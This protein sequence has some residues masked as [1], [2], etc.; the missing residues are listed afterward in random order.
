[1]QEYIDYNTAVRHHGNV[2]EHEIE[3]P[4]SLAKVDDLQDS[5][6]NLVMFRDDM[7]QLKEKHT[8]NKDVYETMFLAENEKIKKIEVISFIELAAICVMGAYQ[9]FRLKGLIA[10]RQA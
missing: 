6:K 7:E 3:V 9:F 5:F 1:M 10:N 8:S 2:Y 4:K